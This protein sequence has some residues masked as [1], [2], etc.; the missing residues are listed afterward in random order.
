MREKNFDGAWSEFAAIQS[1][2]MPTLG[3]DRAASPV[4]RMQ[5]SSSTVGEPGFQESM[6][7][8]LVTGDTTSLQRPDDVTSGFNRSWN[9]IDVPIPPPSN[10]LRR[11][12]S[13]TMTRVKSP[14]KGPV[15]RD[16]SRRVKHIQD[17]YG[18]AG[19]A[20][21]K[22]KGRASTKSVK[23]P[24]G[25][26]K[27]KTS[28]FSST[29]KFKVETIS[30]SNISQAF[31]KDEWITDSALAQAVLSPKKGSAGPLSP[32][33]NGSAESRMEGGCSGSPHLI[34]KHGKTDPGVSLLIDIPLGINDKLERLINAAAMRCYVPEIFARSRSLDGSPP[35][36]HADAY[37]MYMTLPE[38]SL[39]KMRYEQKVQLWCMPS[40]N[41]LRLKGFNFIKEALPA[42]KLG[43]FLRSV[44]T[45]PILTR[46]VLELVN[47][48]IQLDHVPDGL[49]RKEMKGEYERIVKNEAT[50]QQTLHAAAAGR[51]E[52][53]QKERSQ[54]ATEEEEVHRSEALAR[55]AEK[56][57][58]AQLRLRDSAQ[59]LVEKMISMGP[60]TDLSA[61]VD[62]LL[63]NAAFLV[64]PF[65]HDKE[66]DEEE[67]VERDAAMT[68]EGLFGQ[69]AET[70]EELRMGQ[71][72]FTKFANHLV[73]CKSE[74]DMKN[75]T[76]DRYRAAVI[77][78]T[79]Y[80]L[81]LKQLGVMTVQDLCTMKGQQPGTSMAA[82]EVCRHWRGWCVSS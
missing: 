41:K 82:T 46:H 62:T 5:S 60:W 49:M 37:S 18:K 24:H 14:Q 50:I 7:S 39:A 40:V 32:I 33:R 79:P 35:I 43:M 52:A 38:N 45:P 77:L 12:V 55:A 70:S 54:D 17:T 44:D 30:Q 26:S 2:K 22:V 36:T 3:A 9:G 34:H 8:I 25:A 1:Q 66:S 13:S 19:T 56:D 80:E 67:D 31:L 48:L 61:P 58:M 65:D 28:V 73:R 69:E 4:K 57:S 15:D 21:P 42:S 51:A 68:L 71:L 72:A 16:K 74:E 27:K 64:V 53:M 20:K 81:R 78:S 6:L 47:K 63:Q 23:P 75:A 29:S 76:R 10:M 59:R 11:A